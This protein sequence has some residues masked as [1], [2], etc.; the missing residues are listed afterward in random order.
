MNSRTV[1]L[2][3]A[4]IAILLIGLSAPVVADG[5]LQVIGQP[6]L[7]VSVSDDQVAPGQETTI[8]FY[9]LNRGTIR[10]SGP[11]EYTDRVT[12]ARAVN[13]DIGDAESPISVQTAAISPG[14]I[15]TGSSGPHQL[16]LTVPERTE[17]GTYTIP[18][19]IQYQYTSIVNYG[20]DQPEFVDRTRTEDA[21]LQVEIIEQARF[22][23]VQTDATVPIGGDDAI[24]VTIENTGSEPAED[25]SIEA[26]SP[27]SEL[28]VGEGSDSATAYISYL[29]PG[30]QKTVTYDGQLTEDAS[31]RNYTVNLQPEYTDT[32][33]VTQTAEPMTI[34]VG[35]V[36]KQSFSLSNIDA[37]LRAGQDG[38]LEMRITN[39][40]PNRVDN[41][42]LQ[43]QSDHNNLSPQETQYAIG[44]LSPGE[45]TTVRFGVDLSDSA[46]AGPRQFEFDVSYR[47]P[48]GDR[49]TSDII[50][51]RAPVTGERD[52]FTLDAAGTT[53]S[54]GQ[55]TVIE[56]TV[57][58]SGDEPLTD[59]SAKLF[60]DSPISANDDE[61]F[62]SELGPG[63]STTLTFSISAGSGS[64]DKTYPISLDFRY[65]E[66][67][68]DT[69]IS[70][71]YRVPIDVTTNSDDGGLPLLPIG[72]GLLLI[73]LAAGGYI[74]FR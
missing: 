2:S 35:T 37:T 42:V 3:A 10:Q 71:T 40:G 31:N 67:D 69:P 9:V 29:D 14:N 55:S 30:E 46:V 18:V 25:I 15:P 66:P 27:S 44:G 39:T 59:I 7:S 21:D 45:S 54:A 36:P 23:T 53:V 24:S 19:D 33:G 74:R 70:D 12:T 32:D 51:A 50:E 8:E 64:L 6:G 62:V 61:A 28:T 48:D 4:L 13:I 57:A 43:W 68:G 22:D 26:S 1:T 52:I 41:A 65:E 5:H 34:G 49:R 58:N 38:S 56:L 17:P 73:L 72:V 20:G 47:E 63:E 60:A 11:K 16:S